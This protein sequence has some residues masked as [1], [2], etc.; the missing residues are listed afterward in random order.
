M[1]KIKKTLKKKVNPEKS[2]KMIYAVTIGLVIIFG[3]LLL[4]LVDFDDPKDA[5]ES[6]DSA[7]KYLKKTSGIIS[8]TYL[9]EEKKVII[10]YN[11][12]A[13]NKNKY[14]DYQTMARYAAI[15]LSNITFSLS[16][17]P[18]SAAAQ[19]IAYSPLT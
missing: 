2:N 3:G 12:T 11:S 9:P 16:S 18:F 6:I 13:D 10:V 1:G 17:Q 7:L 19:S 14:E 8:V 5:R 15:R 4:L